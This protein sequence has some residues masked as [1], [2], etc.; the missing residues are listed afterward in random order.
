MSVVS[1]I[2]AER[3]RYVAYFESVVADFASSPQDVVRELLVAVN[4]ETLPY[5]Y[6][7]LRADLVSKTDDNSPVFHEIWLDPAS[8]SAARGFQLGPV[9]IEIY[10]FTWCSVQIAFDR[11]LQDLNKFEAFVTHLLDIA[12]E[13]TDPL[14][15]AN[16]IHSVTP[17]ENTGDLWYFTV[18]FGTASADALLDMIDFLANEAMA[19]RIIIQSQSGE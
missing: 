4:T 5:P 19:D 16:A 12:D 6:R 14:R 11:P 9:R 15:V 2:E 17:I 8:G 13:S 18:D 7:Y 10:P 3:N 1:L